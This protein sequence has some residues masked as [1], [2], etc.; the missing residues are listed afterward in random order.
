[1]VMRI[2]ELSSLM[3]LECLDCSVILLLQTKVVFVQF[4]FGIW[5]QDRL[6]EVISSSR[7][8]RVKLKPI[9]AEIFLSECDLDVVEVLGVSG[10]KLLIV[11]V[12]G[13]LLLFLLVQEYV[14][15]VPAYPKGILS[16]GSSHLN[17]R[18]I[19]YLNKLKYR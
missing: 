1:M 17:D 7:L 11:L 13:V 12:E 19:Y 14:S 15:E 16:C 2:G 4:G 3:L 9:W 10:L 8:W 6:T 5:R 18:Y